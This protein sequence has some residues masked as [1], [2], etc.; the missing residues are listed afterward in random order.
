MAL[1]MIPLSGTSYAAGCSGSGCDNKGPVTYGCDG[2]V[3]TMRSV[4]NN[5][6]VAE[7]R[8]SADCTA[9]WVRVTNNANPSQYASYATIE[10]YDASGNLLKSL[11]VDT[12]PYGQSDWSNM[13]GGSQYYYRICVRFDADLYPL[14]CSTKW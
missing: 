13:L 14:K 11:R 5:S 4:N 2:D 12:P 7:L 9:G 8:W 6:R 1:T 10:K 3:T